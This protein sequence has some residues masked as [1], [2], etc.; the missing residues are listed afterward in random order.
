[1]NCLPLR[2]KWRVNM[3]CLLLSGT[4]LIIFTLASHPR[5]HAVQSREGLSVKQLNWTALDHAH[6]TNCRFH[7]CFDINRCVFSMEDTIGVYIGGWYEFH[8]PQTPSVVTPAVSLE[9]A[10]LVAVVKGS[11][12][13]AMDPA[14]ACMFIPPLDTLSQGQLGV[15][16]M[17]TFLNSLPQ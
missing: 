3:A 15:I 13:H 12:Y 11:R 9:Y 2:G 17:S 8:D 4:V 7:T 10:E 16:A 14:H 1:M 6:R 5:N